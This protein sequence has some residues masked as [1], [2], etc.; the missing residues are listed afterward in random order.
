M[1]P[2]KFPYQNLPK[3]REIDILHKIVV[4][5]R[6]NPS[7]PQMTPDFDPNFVYHISALKFSYPIF[8]RKYLET[9]RSD[10]YNSFSSM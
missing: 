3:R 5:K 10:S 4:P 6:P 8:E 1:T 9:Q 2:A 7:R